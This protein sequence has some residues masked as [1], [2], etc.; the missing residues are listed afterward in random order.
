M[1]LYPLPTP[2]LPLTARRT[3]F[4]TATTRRIS[5]RTTSA[6]DYRINDKNQV[7]YRYSKFNWKSVD[8]FRGTFPFART[9]WDRPEL[10]AEL[11]LDEHD[12]AQP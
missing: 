10:D 1:K 11:Q 9:D 3:R 4:S 7:T 2:G 8:A 12:H 6:I 5:G